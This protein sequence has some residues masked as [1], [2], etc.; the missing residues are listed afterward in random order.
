[1]AGMRKGDRKEGAKWNILDILR[2]FPRS[3]VSIVL[4]DIS[5][6]GLRWLKGEL[7]KIHYSIFMFPYDIYVS[8]TIE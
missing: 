8:I 5:L 3:S 1:M 4:T 7:E 2:K 6:C